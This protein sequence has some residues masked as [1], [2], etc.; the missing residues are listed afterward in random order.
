[1]YLTVT[2]RAVLDAR[3]P[4]P[5]PKTKWILG[6][7]IIISKRLL[8]DLETKIVKSQIFNQ[9]KIKNI[10]I[11]NAELGKSKLTGTSLKKC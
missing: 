3:K 1:M 2:V 9:I 7:R 11:Y 6:N 4:I 8:S 5:T 10:K